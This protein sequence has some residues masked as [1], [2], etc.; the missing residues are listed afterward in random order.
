VS[1]RLHQ[2]R[3]ANHNFFLLDIQGDVGGSS[4]IQVGI[5][6]SGVDWQKGQI[7]IEEP[8]TR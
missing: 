3:W 1:H 4:R 7:E 5:S 6:L 8:E 2:I